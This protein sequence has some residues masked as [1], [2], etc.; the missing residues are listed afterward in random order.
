MKRY[1]LILYLLLSLT[2]GGVVN[3]QVTAVSLDVTPENADVGEI[4]TITASSY[5]EDLTRSVFTWTANDKVVKKGAGVSSISFRKTNTVPVVV[6][7]VSII[8][9]NGQ[10]IQQSVEITNQSVD[11]LWEAIDTYTPPFYA[12][13]ALPITESSVRFSPIL[14]RG[15]KFGSSG[16]KNNIYTW[17]RGNEVAGSASGTGRESFP[18]VMD[19][20]LD[21]EQIG[22]R[23][24]GIV[25][26]SIT[27]TDIELK[28]FEPKILF[29]KE[30]I[31]GFIEWN[32]TI[33][34]GYTP[35]K[36]TTIVAAPYFLTP[37]KLNG[38]SFTW[39]KDSGVT[40]TSNKTTIT[41]GSNENQTLNITAENV[42]TFFGTV[43]ETLL[44]N[45]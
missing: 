40:S 16:N 31:N 5:S 42:N 30:N 41:P 6:V 9:T 20:L 45:L 19:Y 28:P 8:L 27:T 3:A 34:N 10:T 32:N 26:R 39:N 22:V 23:V 1:F 13:K 43:K 33:S 29:Y 25:N 21:K 38:V 18:I 44:L 12:G 17:T 14:A 11:L 24:E 15:S 2:I 4:V 36:T 7:G 35:T 37:K